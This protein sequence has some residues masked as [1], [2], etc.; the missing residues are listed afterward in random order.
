MP[1][2]YFCLRS[3]TDAGTEVDIRS[4]R[5][6]RCDWEEVL[7][8]IPEN[9]SAAGAPVRFGVRLVHLLQDRRPFFRGLTSV[10]V[11]LA[12][13][14]VIVRIWMKHSLAVA[15]PSAIFH[16][17]VRLA[18]NG[19]L[20]KDVITSGKE[21]L[22]GYLLAAGFGVTIGLVTGGLRIVGEYAEPI[23]SGFY[24]TPVIALGPLFILWFGIGIDSKVAVCFIL[25]VLPIIINT[26]DGIRDVDP[27][28]IETA[29][30]FSATRTQIF[31][32]VLLPGALPEILTGLRLG[33]G[34]ALL[35]VVAGEL[36]AAQAGLGF[37]IFASSQL[38]NP[39]GV[40]VGITALA[41]AGIVSMILLR[42]VER[43][44]APWRSQELVR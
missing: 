42:W 15:A 33:V 11:L 26:A 28:L 17:Y 19:Q 29:Q 20:G 25:A 13:W 43:R 38:F 2:T 34:R 21:F 24:A 37:L 44:L 23:V 27:H 1:P 7:T 40:F 35:G 10:I 18:G 3:L 39:A 36:F 22:F 31:I 14:E 8:A 30:A 5:I 9:S 41:F 32:K 6:S 12:G 4:L 16:E